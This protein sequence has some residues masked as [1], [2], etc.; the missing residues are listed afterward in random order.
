MFR[1]SIFSSDS[2]SVNPRDPRW[3][4]AL[5]TVAVGALV[6]AVAEL[7]CRALLADV[8]ARWE[9]WHPTAAIKFEYVRDAIR[10]GKRIET[11]VV[12]DSTAAADFDPRVF[13][14]ELGGPSWNAAWSG[15]FP[16]AFAETTLPLLE[17]PHLQ[18]GAIVA[19]FIPSGFGGSDAM[20]PSE[21]SLVSSTFVQK[22]KHG[23]ATGD[24]AWLARVRTAWP[25]LAERFTGHGQPEAV[26]KF[27]YEPLRGVATADAV[28]RE[29]LESGAA[30]EL[31]PRRMQVLLRLARAA[32]ERG[33]RLVVVIPPSLTRSPRR[34]ETAR[35][36][37]ASL[38][39]EPALSDALITDLSQATF[40]S[41]A[42][43]VDLNH[44]N[45]NGASRLSGV[46]ADDL[47][48]K[49]SA[50]P[51]RSVVTSAAFPR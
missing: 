50:G 29:P 32:R 21:V 11:L 16:L 39:S 1:S 34:L 4:R 28:R 38:T 18:V 14:A 10:D 51:G 49:T 19:S 45:A 48:V 17:N 23:S 37:R 40:V 27:G 8:G 2:L 33:A 44:L 47:R 30:N 3:G 12:G 13:D 41:P 15:N 26:R 9:Y 42:D 46:I 36:L 5:R 6:L 24:Y 35:Q 20:T 31:S 25:F 43:F 7:S 22:L